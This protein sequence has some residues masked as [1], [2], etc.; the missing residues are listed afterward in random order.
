[1]QDLRAE[2]AKDVADPYGR[3]T[4]AVAKALYESGVQPEASKFSAD[5]VAEFEAENAFAAAEI[6][7]P[8]DGLP[9]QGKLLV[10]EVTNSDNGNSDFHITYYERP[11]YVK[12]TTRIDTVVG[13]DG[14]KTTA[15]RL[16]M[17]DMKY[18]PMDEA[19]QTYDTPPHQLGMMLSAMR[20]GTVGHGK[21]WGTWAKLTDEQRNESRAKD[22]YVAATEALSFAAA[23][24]LST[25]EGYVEEFSGPEIADFAKKGYTWAMQGS[26]NNK[27]VTVYSTGGNV[28]VEQ[29]LILY[30]NNRSNKVTSIHKTIYTVDKSGA[31]VSRQSFLDRKSEKQAEPTHSEDRPL[32]AAGVQALVQ[33]VEALDSRKVWPMPADGGSGN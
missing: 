11:P 3:V 33:E 7:L 30:K 17:S 15:T 26:H 12:H 9:L 2:R 25:R 32:D 21:V 24:K 1:L 27:V 13:V 10:R 29:R 14:A 4:D 31:S 6:N 28:V 8:R 18:I 5:V 22:D 23:E 16:R 19:P 20:K